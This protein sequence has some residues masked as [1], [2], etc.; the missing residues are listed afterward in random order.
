MTIDWIEVNRV[1]Y[2]IEL[3][4]GGNA[5]PY[6]ARLTEKAKVESTPETYEFWKAVAAS[7]RPRDISPNSSF[8]TDAPTRAG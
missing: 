7:L 1:A 2:Q 5:Y 4:H 6:A 3:D 8:N